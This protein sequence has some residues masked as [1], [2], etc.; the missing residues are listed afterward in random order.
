LS[1]RIN[2][3]VCSNVDPGKFITFF[4]ALVDMKRRRLIYTNAGHNVPVLMRRDGSAIQLA[5]GGLVF[6]FSSASVYQTDLLEL[7]PGDRL[8][9]FT[10]GISEA[11]NAD[12]DEF[13]NERL[14][15]LIS[16][17]R[18][19]SAAGLQEAVFTSVTSFAGGSFQDDATMVVLGVNVAM[20]E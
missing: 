16:A 17:G 6:G 1:A 12:G 20:S 10:D 13:G 7:T 15:D 9:L 11:R 3:L 5:E 14:I 4:Y 19:L 18:Q 8:V 2:R